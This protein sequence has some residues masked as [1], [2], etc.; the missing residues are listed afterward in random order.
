M[1]LT[2]QFCKIRN[3][4]YT[5]FILLEA[6]GSM[7]NSLHTIKTAIPGHASTE[8]RVILGKERKRRTRLTTV[9]SES[10]AV[11]VHTGRNETLSWIRPRHWVRSPKRAGIGNI[12][13]NSGEFETNGRIKKTK[14][15]DNDWKISTHYPRNPAQQWSR[16]IPRLYCL[17]LTARRLSRSPN[18]SLRGCW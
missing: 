3:D 2:L 11:A 18:N 8:T 15:W 4:S 14:N 7:K 13:N 5:I 10:A 6:I 12:Y 16:T 1:T 17:S 9:S